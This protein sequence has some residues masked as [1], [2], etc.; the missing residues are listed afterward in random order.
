MANS[1]A[2]Q[3]VVIGLGRFGSNLAK[4]LFQQ[5]H[6]VLAIDTDPARVQGMTGQVTFAVNGDATQ[7]EIME[8]LGV[9][10]FDVAVVTIGT[11]IEASIMST[12]LLISYGVKRVVARAKTTLHANT[13]RRLGCH[14][15]VQ[16]E[17]E[18]GTYLAH[19]MFHP[20]FGN[21]MEILPTFGI[22]EIVVPMQLDNR[23]LEDIGISNMR[24]K[25]GLSPVA[26]LRDKNETVSPAQ[27]EKLK[28]GDK[29]YIAGP[30]DKVSEL[31][32]GQNGHVEKK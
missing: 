24:D 17:R 16:V 29:L 9:S 32:F 7:D 1:D 30:D 18:M 15:V 5:G 23:S 6:E 3:V 11:N 22:V 28:S 13:L 21:Y 2:K 12:V 10:S 14:N 27:S 25:Y 8:E 4:T 19:K 26:L 31:F 20:D